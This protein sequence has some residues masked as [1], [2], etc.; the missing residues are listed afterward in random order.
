MEEEVAAR[1]GGKDLNASGAEIQFN[2]GKV[3]PP[4]LLDIFYL[5]SPGSCIIWK[6]QGSL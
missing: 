2:F 3:P 5:A 4:D 1:N 6:T